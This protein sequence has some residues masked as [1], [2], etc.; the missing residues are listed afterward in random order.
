[1]ATQDALTA[2]TPVLLHG[3][4]CPFVG[5]DVTPGLLPCLIRT[6]DGVGVAT[7]CHWPVCGH[8]YHALCL[9]RSRA[10]VWCMQC[11]VCRQGWQPG[12]DAELEALCCW[13]GIDWHA[14]QLQDPVP[15]QPTL[16]QP[17]PA[18]TSDEEPA[19]GAGEPVATAL[20]SHRL[21]LAAGPPVAGD[22]L[23][24][25]NSWLFVPLPLAGGG[26]CS[27]TLTTNGPAG[28]R[29]FFSFA[30]RLRSRCLSSSSLSKPCKPL[31]F[32]TA[33]NY[34]PRKPC[35][36]LPFE[37]PL[38]P[39]RHT[40]S[41]TSRGSWSVA[42]L[43]GVTSLLRLRRLFCS[44]FLESAWPRIWAASQTVSVPALATLCPTPSP[45]LPARRR[46]LVSRVA[47]PLNFP[48]NR[49]HWHSHRPQPPSPSTS[50]GSRQRPHTCLAGTLA[51]CHP[52]SSELPAHWRSCGYCPLSR[53]GASTQT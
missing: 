24:A 42:W 32:M 19:R 15:V 12:F 43:T 44:C 50:R 9:A 41:Y 39:C 46:P 27:P 26:C 36:S 1:M 4:S 37:R 5:G 31:P 6:I 23:P 34:P 13:L 33:V 52:A 49:R 8:A 30:V 18:E 38:R 45:R 35:W 21:W 51:P 17:A 14:L 20:A 16:S 48:R 3:E 2:V 53:A 10:H 47:L 25:A 29:A 40:F 22:R 7:P 28:V 11:A